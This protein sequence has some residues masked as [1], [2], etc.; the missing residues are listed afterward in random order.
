M[1]KYIL[2][3]LIIPIINIS[4][5]AQLIA[6]FTQLNMGCS[7]GI[8]DG[9]MQVTIDGGTPPYRIDWDNTSTD[10][11]NPFIGTNLCEGL[12]YISIYD[13]LDLRL[14]TSF[15]VNVFRAPQI[16]ISADPEDPWYIQNPTGTFHF[17][18]L[19]S[20]TIEVEGWKWEFGD[21]IISFD[22]DPIHTFDQIKN[23]EVI[24]TAN[25]ASKCDTT[26]Y[27]EIS[28]KTVKLLI[29]NVITP[30]NDGL[31]D[32]FIITQDNQSS[33]NNPNLKAGSDYPK[34]NAFYKSNE[35]IIFNRWG[36]KVLEQKNYQNDWNGGK[37]KDGVYFYVLKCNGEFEDDIF[38]G[39]ITIM[40]SSN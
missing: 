32:V 31:N 19:S 5:T 11:G 38:R 33:A 10:P 4:A 22:R 2:I 3:F 25:Y 18:N 37:L 21:E 17:T 23:Y 27:F 7:G 35:L 39:S 26:L 8:C 9:K 40:G 24:F 36:Q 6:S 1:K 15:F 30:N 12:Y 29:P 13:A 20:E 28:V 14:D 34:L 16:E